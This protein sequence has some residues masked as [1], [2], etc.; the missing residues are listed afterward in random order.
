L[1][2]HHA[3]QSPIDFI[4]FGWPRE[5][6]A[7]LLWSRLRCALRA[8]TIGTVAGV[9]ALIIHD[10]L[11]VDLP[12]VRHHRHLPNSPRVDGQGAADDARCARPSPITMSVIVGRPSPGRPVAVRQILRDCA[13]GETGWHWRRPLSSALRASRAKSHAR[14]AAAVA[15]EIEV[16]AFGPGSALTDE[17]IEVCAAWATCCATVIHALF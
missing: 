14:G 7:T 8:A 6:M 9:L 15:G 17:P 16:E 13:S 4:P 3:S 2:A 10:G 11:C 12:A 5:A 1:T